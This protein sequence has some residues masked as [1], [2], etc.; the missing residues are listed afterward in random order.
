MFVGLMLNLLVIV[1][2]G[3]LMPVEQHA[4]D[5]VGK[6]DG[7]QLTIGEHIPGSKNVLLDR[8][9]VRLR[10]LSDV[11]L[12]P[13][14]EPYKRAISLGDVLIV[15]GIVTAAAAIVRRPGTHT[16]Q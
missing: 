16:R 10:E 12:L 5:A 2:N 3:G 14:P 15:A 7:A 9:D 1:A 11:I 13:V 8:S 4:V 6:H